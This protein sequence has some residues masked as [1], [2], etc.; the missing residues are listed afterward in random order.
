MS[1]CRYL[2]DTNPLFNRLISSLI[3]PAEVIATTE[4]LHLQTDGAF[5]MN[6]VI[7]GWLGTLG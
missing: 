6:S 3:N 4:M 1:T 2:E 5:F 7:K